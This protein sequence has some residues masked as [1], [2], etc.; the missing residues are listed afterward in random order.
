MS[1]APPEHAA[2]L[3]AL[4]TR[5]A[6]AL[7]SLPDERAA[8]RPAPGKWSPKEIVGHLVDSASNNHERFVR[9][10]WTGDLVCPTYDQDAW[11]ASQRYQEAP[12]SD[13]VVL[14][15]ELNRHIAR[16]MIATP[17][18]DRLRE[19]TRHNLDR[20]AFRPVPA[21]R[22]ATLD[23]FMADYVEHLKHH[24]RQIERATGLRLA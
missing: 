5:A 3:S 16:V 8:R 21:D 10:R 22:A 18:G 11:V 7:L 24:L 20:V 2:E 17:E 1:P 19:R 15:R 6:H 9:A 23:W 12:W 13:L 14:F 4:V